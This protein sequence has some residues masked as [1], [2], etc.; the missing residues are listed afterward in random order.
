VTIPTQTAPDA[1]E[2]LF[3]VTY[4]DACE[5]RE[6]YRDPMSLL[7]RQERV[8][9]CV[10]KHAGCYRYID[11]STVYGKIEAVCRRVFSFLVQIVCY[12]FMSNFSRRSLARK[13]DRAYQF[14]SVVRVQYWIRVFFF[15]EPLEEYKAINQHRIAHGIHA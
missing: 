3:G 6:K 4:D 2:N 11:T 8:E 10:L 13:I 1:F 15:G 7:T 5:K 9:I 14:E 12:P